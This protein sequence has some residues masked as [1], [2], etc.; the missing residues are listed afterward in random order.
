[1]I[2]ST[3]AIVLR[4]SPFSRTSQVVTWLTPA[5][6]RLATIAKGAKRPK[7]P[8]LGQYDLFY[9]CE[10][11][12][13]V[14][15]GGALSIIRECF[16]INTRIRFRSDWKACVCASYVC[17]IVNRVSTENQE[18]SGIYTLLDSFLDYLCLKGACPRALVWFEIKLAAALGFAPRLSHCA[19]CGTDIRHTIP[20]NPVF[21]LSGG[22]LICPSC[23]GPGLAIPPALVSILRQW[24]NSYSPKSAANTVCGKAQIL[25]LRRILGTFLTY[26]IDDLPVSRDIAYDTLSKAGAV[27]NE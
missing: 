27:G 12:Y 1:M 19:V 2:E 26:H 4:A 10:L 3:E 16:P 7:S 17:D 23:K 24:Q 21:S 5:R 11:L 8:L 22:G 15:R 6:G 20:G 18:A 9:K 13:Y 14:R 25:D